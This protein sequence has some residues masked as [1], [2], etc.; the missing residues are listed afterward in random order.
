MNNE[1]RA[2]LAASHGGRRERRAKGKEGRLQRERE[3]ETDEPVRHRRD[4]HAGRWRW[5]GELHQTIKKV[6]GDSFL[7]SA[8]RR[9][10]SP[11]SEEEPAI[12]PERE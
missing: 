9:R 8:P 10:Y 4:R 6:R 11:E 5:K 2:A 7:C 12:L 3:R 1:A